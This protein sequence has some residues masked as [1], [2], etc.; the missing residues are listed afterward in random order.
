MTNLLSLVV[1]FLL[2]LLVDFEHRD[3]KLFCVVFAH[4]L[5]QHFNDLAKRWL[6]SL[7]RDYAAARLSKDRC[8]KCSE[9]LGKLLF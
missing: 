6:R 9:G 3:R 5:L 2:T 7:S 4:H 8:D 1:G